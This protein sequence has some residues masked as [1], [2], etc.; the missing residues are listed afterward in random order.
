MASSIIGAQL[1]E[2]A[3][4]KGIAFS[5]KEDAVLESNSLD[6][7]LREVVKEESIDFVAG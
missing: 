4:L 1:S 2:S 7:D 3:T 6:P 5:L